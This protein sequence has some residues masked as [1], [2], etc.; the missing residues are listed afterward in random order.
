[1]AAAQAMGYEHCLAVS[2]FDEHE[3]VEVDPIHFVDGEWG[4]L[5]FTSKELLDAA[6]AE[7]EGLQHHVHRRHVESCMKD[8]QMLLEKEARIQAQAVVC[9]DQ[10]RRLDERRTKIEELKE[11]VS[12]LKEKNER[13]RTRP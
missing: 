2:R 9:L 5:I 12:A 13:L 1:M 10:Q 8:H 3:I 11:K 6:R 4:N 7:L